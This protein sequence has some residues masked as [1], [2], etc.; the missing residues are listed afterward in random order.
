MASSVPP[1][2]SKK[3]KNRKTSFKSV[4]ALSESPDFNSIP[5]SYKFTTSP[6][7]RK[8]IVAEPDDNDPIP[9]IDYSLLATG[10]PDQRTKTIHNIGK[11][12]EEWGFFMLINHFVSKSL[13]EKMVDQVFAFF[14]LREEEKQEY[15]GKKDVLD[16]IRYGTS[17]NASEDRVLFW[18]DFVKIIVH[19]EFHSP[20]KPSGFRETSEEYSR[21]IW[22]LGKE[23]LKGIS[24][25]L[26]LEL[27]YINRKMNLDSGLQMLAANFY[28]PCPQPELAMGMPP[29]SDHGLLNLLIQNGVSGLQVLHKG[30]WINVS[31]TSNCFLVLVSDHLEIMS[32]GKYKSV[33]HRAAV[34]KGATRM[35]LATVIAPS[36]ETVVEPASELLDN[37]R[38][39]A[40][41]VGMKHIDYMELQR[42]NQ[43][44]GKSVLN[45]V[46]I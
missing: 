30:K 29:H 1:E 44:Y 35:S 12:C 38:N 25:S 27:N 46:K 34:S 23:L 21:R 6:H 20:V 22:K 32:N 33:V 13:V 37:A 10:T 41:Y 15:A 18:R 19:P 16:P 39:P 28:P 43:L 2:V 9:V 11:A 14:N 26:G 4:K 17:F 31:S 3:S 40:A 5:S 45:K 36:L 42:S 24:E 8:E 7:D